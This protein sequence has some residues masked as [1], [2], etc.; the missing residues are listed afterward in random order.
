MLNSLRNVC[1]IKRLGPMRVAVF[2]FVLGLLPFAGKEVQAASDQIKIVTLNTWMIP[3]LR[4]M[5]KARAEAIGR[6][7][8][9]YD[10]ALMQ[11]AFTPGVRNTMANLA[12]G[13]HL[14][15]R[16]QRRQFFRINAGVFSFSRYEITKT[17]FLAFTHCGGAQCLS[18]K[19]VLY[20]QIKLPSGQLLD[21]FNTHL[22]A[23]EKDHRIREKQLKRAMKFI[24]KINDGTIPALFAG[25]FNVIAQ[26]QE[27]QK[28]RYLLEDF[29][30]AWDVLRPNDPGYTWN[31]AIN[32]W[33]KYDYKESQL[34]QRLDYIFVRNGKKASIKLQKIDLAFNEEKMWYGVYLRPNYVFASDHFGVQL[35]LI[36]E[37]P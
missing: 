20:I 31:P 37:R 24:N 30:D 2:I 23:F 8:G 11:E 9:Q 34:L 22:Q 7:L 21:L 16:Y 19:G 33:A 18:G 4:K 1:Y 36:V 29:E 6:E 14:A 28:L 3:V 15:N 35:D 32:Y 5:A 17:D 26:T 10:I 25:D 13:S 27:Y 12:R